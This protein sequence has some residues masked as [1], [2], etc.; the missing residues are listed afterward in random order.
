MKYSLLFILSALFEYL[1]YIMTVDLISTN[2]ITIVLNHHL[3]Y[4]SLTQMWLPFIIADTGQDPEG[5]RKQKLRKLY[6]CLSV[7]YFFFR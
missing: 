6:A 5:H 2:Y 4:S 7:N 1:V 3:F